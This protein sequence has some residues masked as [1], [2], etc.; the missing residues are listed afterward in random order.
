M[1]ERYLVQIAQTQITP[2]TV[3][4]ES[5]QEAIERALRN[6]GSPGDP[7][8]EEPRSQRVIKLEN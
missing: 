7:W 4:A 2:V 1:S 6:E 8:Q 3:V 5:P